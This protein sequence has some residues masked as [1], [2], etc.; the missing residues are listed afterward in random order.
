MRYSK[1]SGVWVSV[2][3]GKYGQFVWIANCLDELPLIVGEKNGQLMYLLFN[4][5]PWLSTHSPYSI[6][7]AWLFSISQCH[8]AF[9]QLFF[10]YFPFI[11]LT[12]TNFID[13][14]FRFHLYR[15][16][17]LLVHCLDVLW[18]WADIISRNR[19]IF[20]S[21]LPVC[22]CISLFFIWLRIVCRWKMSVGTKSKHVIIRRFV[23]CPLSETL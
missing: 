14:T 21:H 22:V 7:S 2:F 10:C 15:L 19:Y 4:F 3:A 6:C 16:N 18:F 12:L 5:S 17:S 8:L 9:F 13:V 23:G 20:F 11:L 1:I